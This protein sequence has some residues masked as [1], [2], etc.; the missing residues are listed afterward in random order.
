MQGVRTHIREPKSSTAWTTDLKN[1]PTTLGLAPS[2][3]RI[4]VSR[5]KLFCAFFMFPINYGQF[6]STVVK[7]RPRYLKEV[8]ISSNL[9]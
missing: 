8:T 5:A 2:R 6:F 9:P 7:T 4:R 3:P 1:I